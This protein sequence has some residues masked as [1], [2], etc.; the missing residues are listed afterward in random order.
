M[1]TAILSTLYYNNTKS[2]DVQ[3]KNFL[4]FIEFLTQYRLLEHTYICEIST[5]GQSNLPINLANHHLIH[6]P[7]PLWHKECGINFLLNLLPPKYKKVIIMDCDIQ[8]TDPEWFD[9][10]NKLLD[11]H[12]MVQ[13][14]EY[15]QYNGPQ[16]PLI[17]N[18]YPSM[19]KH[20]TRSNLIDV[21]NPGAAIAYRRSYLRKIGGLFDQCLVGGADT[22]NIMPFYDNDFIQLSA[23][24]RVCHDIKHKIL[25]YREKCIRVINKS[26]FKRCSYIKD[27]IALHSFH[28]YLKNRSY[29]SRYNLINKLS[30]N[31]HFYKDHNGFYRIKDND[32]DSDILRKNL[33]Q[34][35]D[36]RLPSEETYN[37]P[38]VFNTNKY[39]M[40]DNIFW[41]S[42]L[43]IFTF[44]NISKIKLHFHKKPEKPLRYIK[45]YHQ[46]EEIHQTFD[47]NN[48][49]L[50]IENPSEL[51]ID[52]DYFI[53]LY[54]GDGA[55]IRKLSV[56]LSK[57]EIMDQESDQ[58]EEYLLSNIL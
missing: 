42:D 24:D 14:Y 46:K 54:D 33:D 1:T 23:L 22:I 31:K 12:L 43:D 44:K 9:K 25:K 21:G 13:P 53:P 7:D 20:L 55:D 19:V 51:R 40:S 41:L 4:S 35:F 37:K 10:T 28:G 47:D 18:F 2:T 29:G 45:F 58:Y 5:S 3:Q 16:E 6:N 15:I 38:I 36:S 50:E 32:K 39:G 49:V 30:F 11:K 8:F 27:C 56:Y 34:F 26:S 17:D 52:A 48:L 57:I